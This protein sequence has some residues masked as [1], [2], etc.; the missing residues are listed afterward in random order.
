MT[1]RHRQPNPSAPSGIPPLRKQFPFVLGTTSFIFPEDWIG[2]A[3][4]LAPIV[5]EIEI[6]A[7]ESDPKTGLPDQTTVEA[8][9]K[10]GEANDVSYNVHLP[11][12]V[13][14][15]SHEK[16]KSAFAAARIVEAVRRTE[17]LKP[18]S[19]TLHIEGPGD[20][21]PVETWIEDAADGL[22]LLSKAGIRLERIS[23]ETL[24]YPPEN[25]M[26]LV[27]RFGT[28]ICLDVGH[29]FCHGYDAP[30]FFFRHRNRIDLLHIHGVQGKQDHLSLD[31]LNDSQ[32][33]AL[34]SILWRFTGCV[35][36]EVFRVADLV[37]SLNWLEKFVN[38]SKQPSSSDEL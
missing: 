38:I 12:D 36:I 4:K 23:L 7:F 27:D 24:D 31:C 3:R 5:D 1:E 26:P 15:G 33:A 32:A 19:W 18:R 2:N 16:E 28:G 13:H 29:L 34:L 30:A 17:A 21:Y 20:L 9:R 37:R 6:L 22:S 8:L 25:L 11:T 14:I 35:S 10:I